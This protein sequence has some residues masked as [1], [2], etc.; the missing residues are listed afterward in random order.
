MT[1]REALEA[2]YRRDLEKSN[3]GAALLNLLDICESERANLK[4]KDM[5]PSE[6][7]AEKIREFAG[8]VGDCWLINEVA[9]VIA[10]HDIERGS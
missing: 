3:V 2:E 5:S 10:A 4:L 1:R 9:A 7:L 8:F 6:L